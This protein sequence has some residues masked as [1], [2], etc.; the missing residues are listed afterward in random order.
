MSRPA[1]PEEKGAGLRRD[2]AD[3]VPEGLR[4]VV[5]RIDDHGGPPFDKCSECGESGSIGSVTPFGSCPARSLPSAVE[6]RAEAADADDGQ[7]SLASTVARAD[8]GRST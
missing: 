4:H 7:A 6:V 1:L 3:P 5:E 2:R 8:G